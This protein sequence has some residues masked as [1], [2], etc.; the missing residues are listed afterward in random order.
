[1]ILFVVHLEFRTRVAAAGRTKHDPDP[2]KSN[3]VDKRA[4]NAGHCT[5]T[6]R[7]SKARGAARSPARGRQAQS[8]MSSVLSCQRTCMHSTT[9]SR[10]LAR[11]RRKPGEP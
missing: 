5:H 7:T 10:L 2:I 8:N 4:H 6:G 9:R 11:A 1:M 3:V